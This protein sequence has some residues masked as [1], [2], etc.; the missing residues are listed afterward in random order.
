[1]SELILETKNLTKI[2]HTPDGQELCANRDV[3]LRFYKGRTLGIVGESGCGKSTFARMLLLLE[4]PTSGEI[5]YR[6][7]DILLLSGRE[8]R[9]HRKNIQM[10]FQ[11]P[12]A[13]FSPRMKVRDII[14]E[15]LLNFGRI[16]KSQ[17]DKTAKA[18]LR[19]VDLPEEF[20]DRLPHSMSV[21]QRQRVAIARAL[22]LE[23][24]LIICDEATSALDVSVQETIINLLVRL[25]RE[26]QIAY[27]FISHDIA[28]AG[29]V[30]HQIAVMYLGQ[31]VEIL[32]GETLASEAVHPYTRSLMDAVFD[33]NTDVVRPKPDSGF[34]DS[35]ARSTPGGCPFASRCLRCMDICKSSP[36]LLRQISKDHMAA[37][38]LCR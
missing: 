7:E 4:Q 38:H 29:A 23:P 6:G 9:S 1:M 3:S 24:E 18:Y 33:L 36:P 27:G 32:P 17:T 14:C 37:C 11:D 10:I 20:S 35:A 30:S 25:Q 12:S 8:L 21:G 28:L 19:I 26:K 22:T 31:I 34:S 2:Y 15:P 13:S 16:Q 5:C